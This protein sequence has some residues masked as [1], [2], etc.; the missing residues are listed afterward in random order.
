MNGY[1]R[2]SLDMDTLVFAGKLYADS[3]F[4]DDPDSKYPTIQE[5]VKMAH[6]VA[7]LLTSEAAVQKSR[8]SQMFSRRKDRAD[9]WVHDGEIL[10]EQKRVKGGRPAPNAVKKPP[11]EA[12]YK[13]LQAQSKVGI[14][15]PMLAAPP[16]PAPPPPAIVPPPS[17]VT[18]ERSAE[19]ICAHTDVAPEKCFNLAAALHASK[20][21]GGQIFA[22]RRAK[23]ESWVIDDTNVKAPP[24][25]I[26]GQAV[27][28]SR[29]AKAPEKSPWEAALDGSGDLN[30]RHTIGADAFKSMQAKQQIPDM[31]NLPRAWSPGELNIQSMN[32]I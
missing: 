11:P 28:R 7:K 23:S 2:D 17:K 30:K 5:Q 12:F 21:R 6:Q 25:P 16:P 27:L 26:G 20:G 24:P 19:P 29:S 8:G 15:N 18:F 9:K 31:S 3:A 4:F 22:K 14:W 1:L 13:S 32:N 10:E